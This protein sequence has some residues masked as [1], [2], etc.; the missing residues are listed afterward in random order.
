MK[1]TLTS[2]FAAGLAFAVTSAASAAEV[3]HK[4]VAAYT[5]VSAAL[6]A[7]DLASARKSATGLKTLAESA[8]QTT[9]AKAAS[10]VASADSLKSA[11]AA[12]KDASKQLVGLVDGHSAIYVMTCPMAKADWVQTEQTVANP[13]MGKAM[14]KCGMIKKSK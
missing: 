3:S 4:L 12:F 11:R 9:L 2:I 8:K 13:Y 10:E 5:K 6:V 7:D 14:P 1:K